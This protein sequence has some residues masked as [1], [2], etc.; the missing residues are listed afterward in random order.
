MTPRTNDPSNIFQGTGGQD[1]ENGF[2]TMSTTARYAVTGT[3]NFAFYFGVVPTAS[4]VYPKFTDVDRDQLLRERLH[5]ALGGGFGCTTGGS[6]GAN[7]NGGGGGSSSQ[8]GFFGVGYTS[9]NA[10][11]WYRSLMTSGGAGAGALGGAAGSVFG[12]GSSFGTFGGT[13]GTAGGHCQGDG[14][15]SASGGTGG[16]G[17]NGTGGFGAGAGFAAAN[18]GGG[19]FTVATPA[20]AGEPAVA[21][22]S[23]PAPAA[24]NADPVTFGTLVTT[25]TVA[26][27]VTN[28]SPYRATSVA[29]A[30][31]I[32]QGALAQSGGGVPMR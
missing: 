15:G 12:A 23:V 17:G 19:G 32:V 9:E 28:T 5:T 4:P 1:H 16:Q 29:P 18:G 10:E 11:G 8:P 30:R 14:G 24:T 13:G 3:G 25:T 6:G 22:T 27:P 31:A 26:G 20:G 21:Q 2:L 7:G